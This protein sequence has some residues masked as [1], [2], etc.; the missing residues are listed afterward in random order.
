MRPFPSASYDAWKQTEPEQAGT[1]CADCYA[2]ATVKSED[3]EDRC[4]E[5]DRD[6]ERRIERLRGGEPDREHIAAMRAEH[7]GEGSND[8]R[9]D[10]YEAACDTARKERQE[11]R[12]R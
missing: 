4:A 5:C 10:A 6:E 7:F 3:G 11:E 8:A 2:E 1:G 12:G 9:R